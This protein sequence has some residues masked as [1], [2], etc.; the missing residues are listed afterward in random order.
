MRREARALFARIDLF[1]FLGSRRA[2]ELHRFVARFLD[3]LRSHFRSVEAFLSVSFVS[4]QT[5]AGERSGRVF[6][7]RCGVAVVNVE[8]A[9]VDVRA[10]IFSVAFEAFETFA[11]GRVRLP[12]R[13]DFAFRVL[14]AFL[15]AANVV[16]AGVLR[17]LFVSVGADA[18]VAA[19]S[20]AAHRFRRVG[21]E[22]RV[23]EALVHV[24]ALFETAAAESI[25]AGTL[26][27]RLV[28]GHAIGVFNARAIS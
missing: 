5:R 27:R 4:L 16:H 6:A 14:V 25:F 10:D 19:R 24:F 17:V 1:V 3:A 2:R 18:L 7:L 28:F 8:R 15:V 11:L 12:A 23:F 26:D 22:K 9:L 21:A 13:N 20:V